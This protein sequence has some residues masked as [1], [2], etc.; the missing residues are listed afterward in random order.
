MLLTEPD[1]KIF[2]VGFMGAGKSTLG[3]LLASR[4]G[5]EFQD[6][7]I[8]MEETEGSSIIRIFIEKGEP[9]FRELERRALAQLAASPGRSVIACGGGT[10]CTPENQALMR[11][12][13]ITVWVDQ[14]FDRIWKRRGDLASQRPLLR[15]EAEVSALYEQRTTFYRLA[16]V[17]LAVD[18]M[19]IVDALEVLLRLLRERY[20]LRAD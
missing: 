12:S 17:H 2:L 4:L 15:G 1:E 11:V 19:E 13:G 6:I 16:T 7:D 10:F 20:G 3:R 14:P 8:L 18:E 5:W 9:Y